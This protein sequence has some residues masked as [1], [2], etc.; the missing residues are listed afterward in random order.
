MGRN[1][2]CDR[3][4]PELTGD[5]TQ[6]YCDLQQR[7]DQSEA[8][9]DFFHGWRQEVEPRASYVGPGL[10]DKI[11]VQLLQPAPEIREDNDHA[12]GVERC[13]VIADCGLLLRI[14]AGV[15]FLPC[16]QADCRQH[17]TILIKPGLPA[18]LVP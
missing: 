17:K 16:V 11:A 8:V 6:S 1:R 12:T 13:L 3:Y 18:G 5:E 7:D 15:R 2:Q 9:R 4:I 14:I 10:P